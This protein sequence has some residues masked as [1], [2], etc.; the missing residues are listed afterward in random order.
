[1]QQNL[2]RTVSMVSEFES[3]SLSDSV[4][5]PPQTPTKAKRSSVVPWYP[6]GISRKAVKLSDEIEVF[7]GFMQL[8]DMEKAQRAQLRGA[9]Q[10]AVTTVWPEATV[11]CYGSLAYG[12]SMPGSAVDLV[13][14][15]CTDMTMLKDHLLPSLSER[16]VEV[17]AVVAARSDEGFVKVEWRGLTAN[18]SFVNGSS[19]ARQTVAFVKNWLAQFPVAASV[20]S[21]VRAVLAQVKCQ[22]VA[23]GGLSSYAVLMMI[24]HVCQQSSAPNMPDVVLM[25]FL[26][27][28]GQVFDFANSAVLC[29]EPGPVNKAPEHINDPIVVVDPFDY[30]NNLAAGCQKL[31]QIRSQFQYCYMAL[32][33]WEPNP[34]KGLFRGRTPLSSVISHQSLWTRFPEAK[35]VAVRGSGSS[36]S[37][38]G[39]AM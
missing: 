17:K 34:R 28:F 35:S 1:M 39:A 14:E 19:L 11:K 15:G 38:E 27:L 3:L 12:L 20:F 36:D 24:L 2:S 33:K 5:E 29:T 37:S 13:A 23:T 32:A 7:A 16:G 31:H 30:S 21:V 9:V 6:N 8:S 22:V 18:I 10:E 25:E 26:Y 4:T